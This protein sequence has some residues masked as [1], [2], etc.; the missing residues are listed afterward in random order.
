[1]ES[2]N[3]GVIHTSFIMSKWNRDD[4]IGLTFHFL[5]TPLYAKADDFYYLILNLG[6]KES[7]FLCPSLL[8]H[9]KADSSLGTAPFS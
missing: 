2:S 1:M 3:I 4:C 7:S 8:K 6:N 5:L 9:F